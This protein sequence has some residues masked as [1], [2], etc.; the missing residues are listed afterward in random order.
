M[1]VRLT[2]WLI[3]TYQGAVEGGV[4]HWDGRV[5]VLFRA[6][7]GTWIHPGAEAWHSTAQ[8]G[9]TWT[10]FSI[11]VH[12][13]ILFS[14][15]QRGQRGERSQRG[16]DLPWG[17][18]PSPSPPWRRRGGTR[19]GLPR[20]HRR[21]TGWSRSPWSRGRWP[22]LL[23]TETERSYWRYGGRRELARLAGICLAGLMAPGRLHWGY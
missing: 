12:E 9:V 23:S 22:A 19:P 6:G 17:P 7:V 5:G 11:F 8:P 4:V 16:S 2:E 18:P 1:W 20:P 3:S 13:N 21:G 10:Q 15:Y 14:S